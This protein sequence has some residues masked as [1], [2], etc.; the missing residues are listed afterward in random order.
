MPPDALAN[1]LRNHSRPFERGLQRRHGPAL[2]PD[3]HEIDLAFELDLLKA[4]RYVFAPKLMALMTLR[5][6]RRF[7]AMRPQPGFRIA[8]EPLGKE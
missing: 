4:C 8:T 1:R 3:C 7:L 5:S 2:F 6:A